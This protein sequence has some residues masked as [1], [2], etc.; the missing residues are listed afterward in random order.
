MKS[1]R[2]SCSLRTLTDHEDSIPHCDKAEDYE[3]LLPWNIDLVK[4]TTKDQ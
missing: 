3:A 4:V 1:K 2:P